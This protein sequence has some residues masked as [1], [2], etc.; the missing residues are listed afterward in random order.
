V[1]SRSD[2]SRSGRFRALD[3]VFD[4]RA[5]G[6]ITVLADEWFADLV[7]NPSS[8]RTTPPTTHSTIDVRQRRGGWSVRDVEGV[9]GP[10][11]LGDAVAQVIHLVNQG[12]LRSLTGGVCLH[13]AAVATDGGVVALVG[14]SGAGKSTLAAAAV[15]RG[16]GYVAD[17]IVAINPEGTVRPFHRPIGLRAGGA[18]AVAVAIPEASDGRFDVV[19]PWRP[20]SSALDP[21]G[22]LVGVCL[23]RYVSGTTDGDVSPE[24]VGWTSVRPAEALVEL[25]AGAFAMHVDG[26]DGDR[27][28]FRQLASLVSRVPVARLTYGAD[29]SVGVDHLLDFVA[30][31]RSGSK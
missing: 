21:G 28:R 8:P 19:Y 20:P 4:V 1:R 12:A 27:A 10:G 17:E 24:P 30:S 7:V 3:F 22:P 16:L 13:S 2:R 5:P 9:E 15:R 18:A 25:S 6:E 26:I 23:V 11:D 14:V 29:V 31:T